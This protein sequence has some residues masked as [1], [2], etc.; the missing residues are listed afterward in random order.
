[1]R[2]RSAKRIKLEPFG[3]QEQSGSPSL[4]PNVFAFAKPSQGPPHWHEVY[5]E[6]VKMRAKFWAPVDSQGCERMPETINPGVK[7]RS[8]KTFRFQLL[9]SLMLSSQ[10][11]DE[12]NF[13]AMKALH[14]GLIAKGYPDGL[15]LESVLPLTEKEIDAYICKVGFHNRKASYIR[16]TCLILKEKYGGDIPNTIEDIVSLPGV[17]PKMGYLLLQ[18]AWNINSGIGVDVHLHR[19]AEMWKWTKNAKNPEQ[20]RAQLEEWL[21]K[22]YWSDI[23]PLLVGFGQAICVPK[24]NNCDI[25][26]LGAKGLC[27]SANKKLLGVGIGQKRLEKLQKQRADLSLLLKELE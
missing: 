9:I 1:M 4:P 26:T 11:K 22:E 6:V 3:V 17:G 14:Q 23:N 12:V 2:T 16:N 15:T 5:N 25:C 21:P 13:D 8:P 7:L 24:A 19:L 10:T 18:N 20:T 27:K